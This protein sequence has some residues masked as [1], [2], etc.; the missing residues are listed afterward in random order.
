MTVGIQIGKDQYP[1]KLLG[2]DKSRH[3]LQISN[4]RSSCLTVRWLNCYVH[5]EDTWLSN[6]RSVA[7]DDWEASASTTSGAGYHSEAVVDVRLSHPAD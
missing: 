3:Q 4:L 5:D 7:E 6:G 2:Q 1:L